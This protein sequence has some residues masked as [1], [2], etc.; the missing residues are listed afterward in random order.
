[1]LDQCSGCGRYWNT[2]LIDN[3]NN[4]RHSGCC[5]INSLDNGNLLL[6]LFDVLVLMCMVVNYE[7]LM[8]LGWPEEEE[9][10]TYNAVG[11]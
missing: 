5:S 11:L 4:L 7:D 1:M 10:S 6:I 3:D 9:D 2:K 8:L